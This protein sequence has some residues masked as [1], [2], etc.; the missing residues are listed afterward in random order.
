MSKYL[1]ENLLR[2]GLSGTA[3]EAGKVS[4]RYVLNQKGYNRIRDIVSKHV[5][6]KVLEKTSPINKQLQAEVAALEFKYREKS[7]R[8]WHPLQN[9]RREAKTKFWLEHGLPFDYDIE[10]CAPTILSNLADQHGLH[11]LVSVP[12]REYLQN[13]SKL[14]EHIAGL[15]GIS[16]NDSKRLINS[17]FNG[18][19]LA[20]TPFC[21][22]FNVV[23]QS[24]E[25]MELLQQDR[26]VRRLRTA[27][28]LM[29]G[30]LQRKMRKDLSNGKLK[31]GLYFH[32][33]RMVL[34]VIKDYLGRTGNRHFTEHDGFRTERA[35]DLVELSMLIHA[36]TGLRL[37]V[38]AAA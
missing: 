31:W 9:M 8:Y 20:A 28:K 29:W 24:K 5:D 34:D 11:D 23:G 35:V 21:A 7:D 2:H 4:M 14:R 32:H 25:K 18:A 13:K 17:L 10:T 19:R 1:R 33:E 3:Y 12:I 37:T 22:A 36:R 15:V 26:E 38:K 30:Q 27:V 6:E 16:L